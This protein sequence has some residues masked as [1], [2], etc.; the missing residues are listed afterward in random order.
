MPSIDS[1]SA[2]TLLRWGAH[3]NAATMFFVPGGAC[4]QISRNAFVMTHEA[5]ERARHNVGV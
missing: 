2:E 5:M 4:E 1:V 3:P